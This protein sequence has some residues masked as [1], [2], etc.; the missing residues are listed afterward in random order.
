LALKLD[1]EFPPD[2]FKDVYPAI[3]TYFKDL[4]KHKLE[5]LECVGQEGCMR[6]LQLADLASKRTLLLAIK[7]SNPEL[8]KLKE[9]EID[10][11]FKDLTE[12]FRD[13]EKGETPWN[14]ATSIFNVIGGM[15]WDYGSEHGQVHYFSD[16]EHIIPLY[17]YGVT[18][19]DFDLT[20]IPNFSD[21][22]RKKAKEAVV[23]YFGTKKEK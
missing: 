1:N 22:S 7:N 18:T 19:M 2:F 13:T 12:N 21:M 17:T 3:E 16:H 20:L 5:S 9:K 15:G 14:K 8:N 4:R 11:I 10:K 23:D 6:R